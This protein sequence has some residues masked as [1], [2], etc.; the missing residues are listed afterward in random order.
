MRGAAH[1]AGRVE[2]VDA[3][4]LVDPAAGDALHDRAAVLAPG[5]QL[6]GLFDLAP[7]GGPG[8]GSLVVSAEGALA[9]LPFFV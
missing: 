6:E 1:A 8:T 2:R 5:V 4:Q 9:A 3:D 7:L